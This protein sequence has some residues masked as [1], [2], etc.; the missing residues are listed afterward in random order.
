MTGRGDELLAI[1]RSAVDQGAEL[2]STA[3]RGIVHTKNDRDYATDLDH[4]IQEHIRRYLADATPEFGFLGEEIGDGP[5]D[6][7]GGYMWILDPIDGT[8]NFIHGLPLCAVSL[9]LVRDGEPVIGVIAAPFLDLEYYAAAGQGACGND[10]L[11]T[12]SNTKTLSR[13]I[14]SIGDYA[15]GPDAEPKNKRRIALTAALAAT[16][17]RIRMFGSAALD[18]AWVAEGR[19]DAC[20]ILSNKPWDTAAGVLIAREAG[21][22]VLDSSYRRHS[23]DSRD[24]IAASPAVA[25][26]L[27]TLIERSS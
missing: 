19:I 5:P 24:T 2:L 9:A 17:E 8:S 27:V 14:I 12:A 13:A 16:V 11:I 25:D 10:K 7:T 22:V 3:D 1:A 18:L 26:Q 15:V 21:A 6:S 4:R 23:L 20:V